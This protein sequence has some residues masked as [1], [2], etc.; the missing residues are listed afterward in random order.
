MLPLGQDFLEKCFFY[1]F[2]SI[3]LG[4]L[5]KGKIHSK[6]DLLLFLDEIHRKL[7]SSITVKT[8]KQ[9]EKENQY[10]H[11]SQTFAKLRRA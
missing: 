2:I 8:L 6:S 5:N 7:F 3:G 1:F 11:R 10:F 4:W 9:K